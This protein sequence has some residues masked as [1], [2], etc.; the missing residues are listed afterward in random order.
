VPPQTPVV[1][2]GSASTDEAL[3]QVGGHDSFE[4]APAIWV[5]Q[6]LSVGCH[7]GFAKGARMLIAKVAEAVGIIRYVSARSRGHKQGAI[8]YK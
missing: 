4:I 6:L 8:F 5:L 2:G 1:Y 7:H 3:Q